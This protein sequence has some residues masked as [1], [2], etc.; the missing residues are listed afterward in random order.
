M[1]FYK[2]T[3]KYKQD[4]RFER[5]NIGIYSSEKN[6]RN[7]VEELKQKIGLCVYDHTGSDY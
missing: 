4:N 2:V 3:H 7:A 5:K 1:I 6:A